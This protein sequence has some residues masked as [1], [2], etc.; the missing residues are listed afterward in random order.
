MATKVPLRRLIEVVLVKEKALQTERFFYVFK[1]KTKQPDLI[2][3]YW[4]Y[5]RQQ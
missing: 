3:R 1:S 2:I 4:S 5:P